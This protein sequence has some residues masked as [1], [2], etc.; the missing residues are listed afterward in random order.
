VSWG[1]SP[2]LGVGT[3]QLSESFT[4]LIDVKYGP[5]KQY[6]ISYLLQDD[7]RL[8]GTMVT[9]GASYRWRPVKRLAVIP[10]L[11]G[12]AV[13]AKSV[14]DITGQAQTTG[15]PV[16]IRRTGEGS[17]QAPSSVAIALIPEVEVSYDIVA[18]LWAGV[19]FAALF[20]TRDGP[21]LTNGALSVPYDCPKGADPG[22]VGCAQD[23]GGING[24]KAYGRGRLM[25]IPQITAGYRF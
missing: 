14:D 19:S 3:I 5:S 25:F 10:R 7:L 2:E 6:P 11:T 15:A 1:L 16:A 12:A 13:F 24:E 4:R 17:G 18:G 8:A 23:Y 20:V 22:S 21:E 9:A